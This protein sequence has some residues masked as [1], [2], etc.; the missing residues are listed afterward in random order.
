MTDA[1]T[2][3]LTSSKPETGDTS[4]SSADFEMQVYREAN[5]YARSIYDTFYKHAAISFTLNLTLLASVGYAV[6]AEIAPLYRELVPYFVVGLSGIGLIF[7]SGALA[8]FR[9]LWQTWHRVHVLIR[10]IEVSKNDEKLRLQVEIMDS[11]G[12]KASGP[13]YH[14]TCLFFIALLAFWLT[15]GLLAIY[16]SPPPA[17]AT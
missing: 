4:R 14:L 12:A 2:D 6:R 15:V 5:M 17:A 7:N 3:P 11:G 16:L 8:A 10:N 1:S 9:T 13:V